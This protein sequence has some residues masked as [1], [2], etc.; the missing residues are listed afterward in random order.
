MGGTLVIEG[1][2]Y[3]DISDK[4]SS[5]E[6]AVLSTARSILSRLNAM[7]GLLKNYLAN[8]SLIVE[9][10]V[11]TPVMQNMGLPTQESVIV[12]VD[13][14]RVPEVEIPA[15]NVE[16]PTPE[17][18]ITV[19]T[20]TTP[21]PEV[22]I[23]PVNA[24]MPTP[25]PVMSSI[26][27]DFNSSEEVNAAMNVEVSTPELVISAVVEESTPTPE[28]EIAAMNVEVPTQETVMTAADEET[29]NITRYVLKTNEQRTVRVP[30]IYKVY[31]K[32][33][34]EVIDREEKAPL[35]EEP[36]VAAEPIVAEEKAPLVEEPIAAEESETKTE[37]VQK[38]KD[39]DNLSAIGPNGMIER[40]FADVARIKKERDD[41]LNENKYLH[42]RV[43]ELNEKEATLTSKVEEHQSN[44]E[45]L[46]GELTVLKGELSEFQEK[47]N[48]ETSLLKGKLT[49]MENKVKELNDVANSV[50]ELKNRAEKAEHQLD[51]V[52]HGL[53][54]AIKE[55]DGGLQ[56]AA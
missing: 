8:L 32:K 31:F 12:A 34:K 6:K 5:F 43:N 4:I 3:I 29:T 53:Q 40:M 16:M 19:A 36:I 37:Q 49:I 45:A 46:K 11:E 20:S 44:N 24:E 26:P 27:V 21:T 55:T 56:K 2:S 33:S 10:K 47:H 30:H 13:Q 25:E 15:M 48:Q 39:Q 51:Y 9:K 22:E 50:D 42:G 18:E 14:E 23:A 1:V 17:P 54:D 35:V 41:A 38:P 7:K 52:L 28:V